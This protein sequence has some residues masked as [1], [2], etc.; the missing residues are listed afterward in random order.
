MLELNC[1]N[2]DRRFSVASGIRDPWWDFD[3]A[4]NAMKG[5]PDQYY[6]SVPLCTVLFFAIGLES[7]LSECIVPSMSACTT[8]NRGGVLT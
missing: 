1:V 3:T 7:L 6:Y 8:V 5:L 4:L 2:R